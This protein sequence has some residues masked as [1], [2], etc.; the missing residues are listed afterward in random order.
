VLE[1]HGSLVYRY[2]VFTYV[3]TYMHMYC[4]AYW[5]RDNYINY[6]LRLGGKRNSQSS[7]NNGNTRPVYGKPTMQAVELNVTL[8]GYKD[9]RVH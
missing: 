5:Q 6:E 7:W 9:T 2:E 4:L 3:D 1:Q 8:P